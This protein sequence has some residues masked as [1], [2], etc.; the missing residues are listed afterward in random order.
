MA[1][2]V[3]LATVVVVGAVVAVV[4]LVHGANGVVARVCVCVR[5][6][7]HTNAV[8]RRAGAR[9]HTWART[10]THTHTQTLTHMPDQVPH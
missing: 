4:I 3:V 2:V 10:H 9:T 1:A 5:A 6:H 8:W 7:R